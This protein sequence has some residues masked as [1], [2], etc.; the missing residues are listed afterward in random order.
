[1]EF[2]V[3]NPAHRGSATITTDVW[4]KV[5]DY[6]EKECQ[7]RNLEL[8]RKVYLFEVWPASMAVIRRLDTGTVLH[9]EYDRDAQRILC[10]SADSAAIL[11]NEV[12]IPVDVPK[13]GTELLNTL[14][15]RS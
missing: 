13:L 3:K 5:R 4:M 15:R 12:C 9:L 10:G 8:G 11:E 6:I 1:M 14:L 2:V 7:K